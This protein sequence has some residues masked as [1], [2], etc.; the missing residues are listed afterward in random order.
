MFAFLHSSKEL[1]PYPR[2]RL[3][4][5]DPSARYSVS[6][7]AGTLA[8]G[9]PTTASGAYWMQQGVDIQL[10]GDFQAAAFTLTRAH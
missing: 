7:I 6:S 4:G 9:T 1:Y 5:L 10:R 8:P 3:R 2:V